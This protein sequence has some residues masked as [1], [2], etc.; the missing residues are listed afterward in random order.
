LQ[1]RVVAVAILAVGCHKSE[2]TSSTVEAAPNTASATSSSAIVEAR[3]APPSIADRR[4]SG[5]IPAACDGFAIPLIEAAL[6]DRCAV[7]ERDWAALVDGGSRQR[8]GRGLRQEVRL[9][10]D[11]VVFSLVNH[12]EAATVIPLRLHPNRPEQ[13]VSVVVE[14]DRH[15]V[16]ELFP[17]FIDVAR[18]RLDGGAG[19]VRSA[20]IRVAA[21]GAASLRLHID[22]RVAKRLDQNGN[23]T[24]CGDAQPCTPHHLPKERYVLYV[25]QLITDV[26]AGP[27]AHMEWKAL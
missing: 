14:D 13:A 9:D 26:D 19:R 11:A 18:S 15:A 17:P 3:G 10:G 7:S 24:P 8:E 25:G 2:A 1:L 23:A 27:P 12:G 4:D 6:D 5:S 21:G 22:P 16:F 20:R